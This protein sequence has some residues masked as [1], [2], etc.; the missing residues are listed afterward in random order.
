[1][2]FLR[3]RSDSTLAPGRPTNEVGTPNPCCMFRSPCVLVGRA[4]STLPGGLEST[5]NLI[6]FGV[7]SVTSNSS[8][9]I[10]CIF[11]CLD[12]SHLD[13]YE[14][15]LSDVETIFASPLTT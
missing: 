1:M 10:E 15:A 12:M 3:S 5:L 4:G 13:P 2:R 11:K 8:H 6:V 9:D 14:I 7:G